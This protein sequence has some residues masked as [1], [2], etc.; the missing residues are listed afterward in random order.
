MP[1]VGKTLIF[2]RED[3]VFK[4]KESIA[5]DEAQAIV[6]RE[7][8]KLKKNETLIE[9]KA[10]LYIG[11]FI[12]LIAFVMVYIEETVSE[13]IVRLFESGIQ[14][15]INSGSAWLLYYKPWLIYATCCGC[16]GLFAGTLTTYYGPGA[17]GSGVAEFIGF[18]NGINYSGE[19]KEEKADG[20]GTKTWPDGKTYEGQF[21]GGV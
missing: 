15:N 18:I 10:Y 6:W 1:S 14:E 9:W 12:G 4:K 21:E 3:N 19:I 11:F 7:R 2:P 16:C 5:Y 17:A 13:G 8:P 20:K